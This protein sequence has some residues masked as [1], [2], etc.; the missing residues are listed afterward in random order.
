MNGHA[1]G[2]R[3]YNMFPL[4][5]GTVADW[6][7]HLDRIAAMGFDWIYVNPFH[8]PGFSGSLYAIKQY[9]RLNPIF[10]GSSRKSPDKLI[11]DYVAAARERGISVM[12]DL[13]INHTSKDSLLAEEHPEWFQREPD[14]S[15]HSPSAIDPADARNVTV[16]EDL[17]AIEYNIGDGRDALISY[18]EDLVDHYLSLGIRGFRCDAAYQVPGDVWQRVIE[19]ARDT[20]PDAVFIAETLG[21]RLDQV[22]GLRWAGFDFL[23][24][25]SKWWD[26]AQGW[27]LDQYEE[28]RSIAPSIAFPESHDTDRLVVDLAADGITDPREVERAYRL[29]YLFSAVFSAG[30][31]MPIGYEYGFRSKLHVVR[32][33]PE[34]WEDP[35]FDLTDFIAE[36]NRMKA[37]VP[38]FNEEGPQR[39]IHLGEGPFICLERRCD[40]SPDWAVTLVNADLHQGATARLE[41]LDEAMAGARRVTHG[42]DEGET[43]RPGGMVT[44]DPGEVRVYV[45]PD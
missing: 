12:M 21:A 22:E 20:S 8:Y 39:M 18:W 6:H 19:S 1:Q 34:N 13:V 33:R 41:G 42:G 25:S 29:R 14:G 45:K 24:N 5:V 4:L 37:A 27:L 11:A 44:V 2:P 7:G 16:W 35:A 31:M 36:T 32:T 28:F 38:A 15:L 3:V 43:L 23:Y 17:A 10:Q 30:L 40:G 26:F 9:D